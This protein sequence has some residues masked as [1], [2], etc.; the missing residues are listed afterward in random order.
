MPSRLNA[1]AEEATSAALPSSTMSTSSHLYPA[2][3]A[4]QLPSTAPMATSSYDGDGTGPTEPPL[5][6]R[7]GPERGGATPRTPRL[8]ISDL[9]RSRWGTAHLSLGA[10]HRDIVSAVVQIAMDRFDE[11]RGIL[12]T[13]A[14][15]P[16]A[17]SW[18]PVMT[19]NQIL[20]F[21]DLATV[22]PAGGYRFLLCICWVI[23]LW[24]T[25]THLARLLHLI[26]QVHTEIDPHICQHWCPHLDHTATHCVSPQVGMSEVKIQRMIDQMRELEGSYA[27]N[28]IGVSRQLVLDVYRYGEIQMYQRMWLEHGGLSQVIENGDVVEGVKLLHQSRDPRGHCH[29][30]GLL[31]PS[32]PSV[33]GRRGWTMGEVQAPPGGGALPH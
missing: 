13:A 9:I 25:H 31:P 33:G 10:A 15:F 19:R 26:T 14:D 24:Q 6:L 18:R 1:P 28:A 2:P 3:P 27:P 4:L 11:F 16:L 21:N 23:L 22:R 32:L 12:V 7:S 8:I 30:V 29:T 5:P 17:S 20:R